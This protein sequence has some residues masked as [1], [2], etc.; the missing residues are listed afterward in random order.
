MATNAESLRASLSTIRKKM[1]SANTADAKAYRKANGLKGVKR[2]GNT[3]KRSKGQKAAT[4]AASSG[5][6][7]AG[8]STGEAGAGN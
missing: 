2:N 8:R 6:Q 7:E 5:I 1:R 3:R 4:E